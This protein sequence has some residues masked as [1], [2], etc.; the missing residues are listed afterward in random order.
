ML[1]RLS[2]PVTRR[3]DSVLLQNS[4]TAYVSALSDTVPLGRKASALLIQIGAT[5]TIRIKDKA[6]VVRDIDTTKWAQG[7]WHLV[8]VYQ[9]MATGTTAA[10]T[11]FELGWGQ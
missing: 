6:G 1:D 11:S 3:A 7:V 5:G 10:N 4:P 9:V 2:L 8:E